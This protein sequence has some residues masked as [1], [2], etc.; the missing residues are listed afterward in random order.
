[1]LTIRVHGQDMGETVTDCLAQSVENCRTF[2]AVL[3][4]HEDSQSRVGLLHLQQ[5]CATA[6]IAAIHHNPDRIPVLERLSDCVEYTRPGVIARNQ[7]EM[8]C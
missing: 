8:G 5:R 7:D 2:S 3:G 4:Q 1:M 6:I